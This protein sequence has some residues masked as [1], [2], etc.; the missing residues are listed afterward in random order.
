MAFFNST[1]ELAS[2]MK[3][4]W[5]AIAEDSVISQ[6]LIKSKMIARFHYKDPEGQIT[7]DCS[8]GEN[9]VTQWGACDKKPDVEMFMKADVAHEFWRGKVNVP[10][11]LLNGKMVAKGPVN[12][13][14]ALLPAIKPAFKKY[15]DVVKATL[16]RDISSS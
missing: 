14:L 5:S 7:I 13:A 3:G 16:N 2:V 1:D 6:P 8:D 11:Y 15:P 9:I 10:M 12:K 4:L